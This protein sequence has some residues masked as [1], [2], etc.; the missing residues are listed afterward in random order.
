MRRLLFLASVAVVAWATV[1]VQLPFYEVRPGGSHPVEDIIELSASAGQINGDLSLLTVRQVTSTPW[2][3]LGA[4]LSGER[5]LLPAAELIP[6]DVDR[7]VFFEAQSQ[8]FD[9]AFT[10]AVAVAARAAGYD[11][12]VTTAA[13]IGQVLSGSPSDGL[14]RPG[15]EVTA[16]E[17]NHQETLS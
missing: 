3:A 10:T 6:D 13:V 17:S 7:D 16:I 4:M 14:L 9:N 8:Q 5:Q 2:G 11:I 15:D 12:E 1:A